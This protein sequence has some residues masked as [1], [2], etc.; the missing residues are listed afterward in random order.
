MGREPNAVMAFDMLD[1]V[2][3]NADPGTVADDMRMHR[4][5]EEPSFLI[6]PVKLTTENFIDSSA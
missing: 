2:L 1:Q 6:S 4:Q 5:K 3:K